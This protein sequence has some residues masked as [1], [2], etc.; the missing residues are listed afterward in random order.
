MQNGIKKAKTQAEL[1]L[2]R[3][4]KN[5]KKTFCRYTD[6]KR[7]AKVTLPPL[8][9]VKGEPPSTDLGKA[10]VLNEIFALL[11]TAS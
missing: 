7:Q 11:F 8:V 10:E 1:N 3:D 4:I 9:N 6:Q 5:N 2:V